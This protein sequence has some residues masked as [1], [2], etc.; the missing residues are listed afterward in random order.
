VKAAGR[1]RRRMEVEIVGLSAA[2]SA[3]ANPV[4]AAPF[5]AVHLHLIVVCSGTCDD[6][7]GGTAMRAKSKLLATIGAG[8]VFVGGGVGIAEA[9]GG[10]SDDVQATG[11]AA[12]KAKVAA[13]KAVGS[14]RVVSVERESEAGSA[15]QVE[16]VRRDG[17]EVEASLDSAY[18]SVATEREDDDN[19]RKADDD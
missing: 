19:D 13:L 3:P 2:G 14:G 16:I 11:A 1:I 5:A 6:N 4:R 17:T 15:W 7:Q 12:G 18:K 10:D 9:V 8:A